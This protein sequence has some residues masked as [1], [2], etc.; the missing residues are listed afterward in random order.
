[1][2]DQQKVEQ[3]AQ[4]D[5][6]NPLAALDGFTEESQSE[7]EAQAQGES[8]AASEGEQQR[9]G[10]ELSEQAAQQQGLAGK[11]TMSADQIREWR[12][13]QQRQSHQERISQQLAQQQQQIQQQLE[14]V[15]QL[16][17]LAA[18]LRTSDVRTQNQILAQLA[19]I[20]AQTYHRDM[21]MSAV[22]TPQEEPPEKLMARMLDERL[23]KFEERQRQT[24][25]QSQAQTQVINSLYS[26]ASTGKYGGVDVPEIQEFV[27][28][29]PG[30]VHGA[31]Q[32]LYTIG[33]KL[34]EQGYDFPLEKAPYAIL[35]HTQAWMR[36]EQGR[37][38]VA[39]QRA[40]RGQSQQQIQPAPGGRGTNLPGTSLSAGQADQASGKAF[41]R[42]LTDQEREHAE[43]AISSRD[44]VSELMPDGWLP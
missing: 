23:S 38:W 37:Q 7:S 24:Q 21:T 20:D 19:G 2:G 42:P 16:K 34:Y 6:Y 15:K 29:H 8:E 39:E 17:E 27:E 40:L 14:E 41:E 35:L 30:G 22:G 28:L 26:T 3:S 31:T 10:V 43:R 12:K 36:S 1:M 18:K 25:Q 44:V 4:T 13:I 5:E 32:E 9:T 11:Q 33:Q